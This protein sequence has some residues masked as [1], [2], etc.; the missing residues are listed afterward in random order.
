[1]DDLLAA[2]R[3]PHEAFRLGSQLDAGVVVALLFDVA[4]GVGEGALDVCHIG[5]G[6]GHEGPDQHGQTDQHQEQGLVLGGELGQGMLGL[7]GVTSKRR[8]GSSRY[9]PT[10][11]SRLPSARISSKVR[12]SSL[13]KPRWSVRAKATTSPTVSKGSSRIR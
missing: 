3:H 5:L 2:F 12:E 8:C 10:I 4:G 6:R 13:S 11:C 9:R 1:M 7:H